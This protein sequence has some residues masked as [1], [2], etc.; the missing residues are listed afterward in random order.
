[1]IKDQYSQNREWEKVKI[2]RIP[3]K[4]VPEDT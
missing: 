3:K 1:M 4:D 2:V